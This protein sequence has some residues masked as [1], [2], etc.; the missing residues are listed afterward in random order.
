[1]RYRPGFGRNENGQSLVEFA[2]VVPV[3]LLLLIGIV[4]FGWLFN[5]QITLTAAAREGARAGVTGA[6]NEGHDRIR[7]AVRN[8]VDG[9]PGF[10]FGD[11]S[12][13]EGLGGFE[14]ELG[15][16]QVRVAGVYDGQTV[17]VH[18]RGKMEP[19]VGLLVSE[20]RDLRSSAVMRLE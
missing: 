9:F 17:T 5:G 3:L 4:E 11:A 1:M 20:P 7:D 19:L 8:Y 12:Y 15:P 2:I 18:I 10:T 14:G 16:R 6:T 13:T